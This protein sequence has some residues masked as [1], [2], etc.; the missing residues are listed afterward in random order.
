LQTSTPR[1]EPKATKLQVFSR[2]LRP[3]DEWKRE[4]ELTAADVRAGTLEKA[5]L[6][7]PVL[8]EASDDFDLANTLRN[9]SHAYADCNIFAVARDERCFLGATPEQLAQVHH[10]E[11]RTMSLAGTFRRGETPEEDEAMGTALLE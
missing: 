10:G 11:V 5:V 4:V 1:P 8:L 3:V 7:R 6:A 9:L 2:E